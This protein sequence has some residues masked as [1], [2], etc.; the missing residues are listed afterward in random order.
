[1][2]LLAHRP[3]FKKSPVVA[4]D[5]GMATQSWDPV[6]LI[7]FQPAYL[8][9]HWQARQYS[10]FLLQPW[11]ETL[12]NRQDTEPLRFDAPATMTLTDTS[13]YN[14]Q[15]LQVPPKANNLPA[16]CHRFDFYDPAQHSPQHSSLIPYP[17]HN[18]TTSA[19]SDFNHPAE[20]GFK[21]KSQRSHRSCYRAADQAHY[22]P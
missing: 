6:K 12:R 18:G 13:I 4:T 15:E 21:R 22:T 20:N 11:W 14:P 17:S 9:V 19:H 1:M 2:D 8:P 10:R 7:N 3:C 5:T 16:P